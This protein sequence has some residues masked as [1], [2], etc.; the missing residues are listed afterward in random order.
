MLSHLPLHRNAVERSPALL[1]WVVS[2]AS[3]FGNE[4]ENLSPAGWFE[5]GHDSD[6]IGTNWDGIWLPKYRRG[7]MVWA[8]LPGV[9]RHVVEELRKAMH[10]RQNSFHVFVCPSFDVG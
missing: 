7:T 2:L 5:R 8:P 3:K 1:N 9:A 10:K 4:V 6:G